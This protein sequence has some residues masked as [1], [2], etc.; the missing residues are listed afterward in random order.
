MSDTALTPER[1]AELRA[2]SDSTPWMDTGEGHYH[3]RFGNVSREAY[4]ALLAAAEEATALRAEHDAALAEVTR[5][6]EESLAAASERGRSDATIATLET[7]N[8]RLRNLLTRVEVDERWRPIETAP[9]DGSLFM[10]YKCGVPV[11]GAMKPSKRSCGSVDGVLQWE[12]VIVFKLHPRDITWNP[13]HWRPLPL[14][15]EDEAEL[16]ALRKAVAMEGETL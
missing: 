9:K 4:V 1:I 14:S 16:D 11:F 2:T 7:E 3:Y 15:P 13:T 6:K 5:L 8:A 12:E 10:A